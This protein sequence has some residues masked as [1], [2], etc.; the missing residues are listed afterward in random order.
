MKIVF[1]YKGAE[2]LGIEYISS[3]L[4]SEGHQ[5]HLF[6]DPAIFSGDLINNKF[7][8]RLLNVDH[9]IQGE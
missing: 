5:V 2:N 6:F 4:K 8:A 3:L 1:V 9:K 7:V